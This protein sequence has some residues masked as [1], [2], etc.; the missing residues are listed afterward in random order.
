[1]VL[2]GIGAS[3]YAADGFPSLNELSSI[4]RSVDV[5]SCRLAYRKDLVKFFA[6]MECPEDSNWL[7]ASPPANLSR[8][9]L[10]PGCLIMKSE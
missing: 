6:N 8:T 9:A 3:I 10:P 7:V 1:M 4:C 5:W 2:V